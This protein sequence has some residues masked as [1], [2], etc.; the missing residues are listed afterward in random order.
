MLSLVEDAQAVNNTEASIRTTTANPRPTARAGM[1]R[2][3]TGIGLESSC[4]I[5]LGFNVIEVSPFR[6]QPESG[7]T[8]S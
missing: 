4:C 2:T 8:G 7:S 3:Q 1:E 5:V 6:V